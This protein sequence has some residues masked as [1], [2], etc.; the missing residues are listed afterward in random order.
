MDKTYEKVGNVY[1][2][3]PAWTQLRQ[4]AAASF[5]G[6]VVV[7][8]RAF[9]AGAATVERLHQTSTNIDYLH[10]LG[11]VEDGGGNFCAFRGHW[12]LSPLEE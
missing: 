11:I 5:I 2:A 7:M 3:K 8:A 12:P 1:K 9:R 6:L 4:M 10:D